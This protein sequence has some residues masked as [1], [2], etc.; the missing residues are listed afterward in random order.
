MKGACDL[1][2]RLHVR[3]RCFVLRSNRGKPLERHGLTLQAPL[4]APTGGRMRHSASA[5]PLSRVEGIMAGYD[6]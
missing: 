5:T 2:K 3:F 6:Y 1:V 4:A